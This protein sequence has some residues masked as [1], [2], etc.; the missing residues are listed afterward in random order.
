[1]ATQ[2]VQ[3]GFDVAVTGGDFLT[4]DDPIKGK[5][6]D[7]TYP[8]GGIILVDVT[9]RVREFSIT[10]GKSR[11]LDRYD[12][13]EAVI[14]FNNLDRAFD[15]TFAASPYAGQ[16][17]PKREVQ[18]SS[19][20]I[21]QFR[22]FIDD[23]NLEYTTDGQ[24][25]S[26]A[27]ASDDFT[28]LNNRTLSAQTATPQTSGERVNAI[29]SDPEVNYPLTSRDVATG[30]SQLGA[31]EIADDTN[32]L[33]YL[34]LIEQ[35]EPGRLFMSKDNALVFKDRLVAPTS[36]DIVE[37]SDDG[38]G[39]KY[40]EMRVVFGTEQ[41]HNEVV[42]SS[43]ITGNTAVA[44]DPQS[45]TEYGLLN[46]TLTDLLMDS[47]EQASNLAI[48]LASKYSQPEYRFE[49]V[50]V[51]FSNL[52]PAEQQQILN[53]ELGDVCKV[54]FTP[55]NVPPAIVRYAEV[56]GIQHQVDLVDQIVTLNFST[57][58][59][60]YLVLDDPVFGRLD[61]GNALAF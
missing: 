11:E 47:D 58:D 7:A 23:W 17:L 42:V 53:L 46:L 52:T 38:T 4:L 28:A 45:I 29:L 40:G 21:V 14:E 59:F 6:D 24:A 39:I 56:I 41:L 60:T 61:S 19:D 16:I 34:R 1:M 54:T 10:R 48:F 12:A 9:E 20:D 50:D 36:T 5:L 49:S 32:A 2:K 55:G 35:T 37:L 33:D 51:Q 31:D 57:L 3:I 27:V 18:I 43:V 13:G 44:L 8:L 22:G 25:I 30:I 15:P 26:I